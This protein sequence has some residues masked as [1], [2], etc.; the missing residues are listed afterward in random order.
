MHIIHT[1][2]D[3]F[4]LSFRLHEQPDG[5]ENTLHSTHADP[6]Q[7]IFDEVSSVE[8]EWKISTFLRL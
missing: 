8:H 6:E 4:L 2:S 1:R 3:F 5:F 7:D